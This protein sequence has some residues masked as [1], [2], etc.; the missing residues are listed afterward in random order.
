MFRSL[1]NKLD[2]INE[3]ANTVLI[4]Y[5]DEFADGDVWLIKAAPDVARTFMMLAN[6]VEDESTKG[7]EYDPQTGVMGKIHSELGNANPPQWVPV[8]GNLPPEVQQELEAVR[9]INAAVVNKLKKVTGDIQEFM[10]D[11]VWD[12]E[13]SGRA[14]M[15][16]AEAN[17]V[18]KTIQFADN[19]S[20]N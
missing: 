15:T 18:G 6:A 7:T 16:G 1:L 2:S 5:I 8:T 17:Y 10:A 4:G 9:P 14:M 13:S 20:I 19:R 3:S 11:F 12:L